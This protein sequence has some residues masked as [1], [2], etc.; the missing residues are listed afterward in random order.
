MDTTTLG[1]SPTPTATT[2]LRRLY[3]LR[4]AFAAVWAAALFATA[5]EL[6]PASATLLVI[7]PSS[8]S[9]VPSSICA[10]PARPTAP[11]SSST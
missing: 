3:L 6:S 9:P 5:G 8:T 7:Y 10:P 2:D 11:Y 4:F 1:T